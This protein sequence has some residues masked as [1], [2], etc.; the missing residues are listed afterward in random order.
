MDKKTLLWLRVVAVNTAV[1]MFCAG[2]ASKQM[3][4][5]QSGFLSS[6]A[7]LQE[8]KE[9]DGM[10]VYRNPKVNIKERY[11][12]VL[13]AP[14]QFKLDPTVTKHQLDAEHQIQLANYFQARL[15]EGLENNYVITDMPGPDVLLLR[16]AI[17]DIL[18]SKVYL[19]LHWSTTLIGGGIG[20][21]SLEAELVDSITGEQIMAFVDV[22]K[23]KTF[24]QEPQHLIKNYTSGLTK[25]G[26]TREV[27]GVWADVMALNLNQLREKFIGRTAEAGTD[28]GAAL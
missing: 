27:M 9:L 24:L 19:N 4:L 12:K 22:R 20:G 25:W 3:H 16:T 26:H 28:T 21:A 17:T 2:C 7:D 11:T 5:T 1:L 14:V 6:Y 15:K 8:D 13:I 23:G 18:P 10:M